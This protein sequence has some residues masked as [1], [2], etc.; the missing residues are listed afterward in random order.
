MLICGL[1][2]SLW[3][4]EHGI[5]FGRPGNR[6]WPAAKQAGL[7][8]LDRDPWDALA[9]GMGFTDLVKKAT[10]QSSELSERDYRHGRARIEAVVRRSAP[11]VVCFVGLE[12]WRRCV[13]RRAKPGWAAEPFAGR[14]AYLMPSTSGRNAHSDLPSLI[15]HLRSAGR[16]P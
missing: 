6:F 2:P 11:R 10:R 16:G 9:R 7:V 8:E 14:P 5:P 3:S 1:N 13:D 4:A 12:G 15:E